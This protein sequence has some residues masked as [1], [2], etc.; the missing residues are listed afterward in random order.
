MTTATTTLP[1]IAAAQTGAAEPE[2]AEHAAA[3]VPPFAVTRPLAGARVIAAADVAL[4]TAALLVAASGSTMAWPRTLAEVSSLTLSVGQLA[5]L[6]AFA[7]M[8]AAAFWAAGL[9]DAMRVRRRAGEVARIIFATTAVAAFAPLFL[10]DAQTASISSGAG[11]NFWLMGTASVIVARTV[12]ARVTRSAARCRRALIV[13][14]GPHALRVCRDLSSDPATPYRVL[15]FVDTVSDTTV[16]RSRFVTRRTVG[17]LS[18]LESILVREHIDEVHVGLPIRSH[19]PQIQETIRVCERVG[20]KLM[21]RAD[22]FDTVL[23]RPQMDSSASRVALRVVTEGFTVA[24]KRAIDLVGAVTVLILASPVMIAAAIAIK[25]TSEGPV[26]FGQERY[27]LNRRRFRMLK[28]RTMV[29]NAERLQ[30]AL[31]SQNEAQGPVFKIARDPR[32]TPIGRILRRTSIDE[33]PQLFNVLKGDMSLI[34]PR[35]LPLRDVAKFT[36]TSDMRRFS[37]RPGLTGLWQVSGRSNLDF[38]SWIR[39]DLHYIDNWSLRLDFM[40]LARTIPAVIRGT[41]AA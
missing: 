35:P 39:F 12:R 20:V 36:R 9:Y 31:E 16:P 24:V 15:G 8:S 40:I 13:G 5:R 7:A 26:I 18:D 6:V 21:Y 30:A 19:Y 32:I 23:A 22:V 37:V 25:L 41:G 1:T 3:T 34:G 27:G 4:L 14:S 2:A 11:I 29:Q 28:F 17:S 38:D 10:T 33:L